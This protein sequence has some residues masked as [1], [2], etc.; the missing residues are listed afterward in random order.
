MTG[1]NEKKRMKGKKVGQDGLTRRGFIK[2]AGSV[3]VAAAGASL[4]PRVS[5]AAQRDYILVG[6]PMVS[7]GPLAPFG[8]TGA[9]AG[10]F[11]AAEINKAG[12]IFIK[13]LGKKSPIRMKPVDSESDPTKAGELASKLILQDKVDMM[14]VMST[15]AHGQSGFGHV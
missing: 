14:F 12:G 7:T 6:H 15:P 9:F 10:E 8:E 4:L 2:L 5:R 13:E 3:G 1:R 11:G